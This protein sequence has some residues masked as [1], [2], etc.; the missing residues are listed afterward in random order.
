MKLKLIAD[1][2]DIGIIYPTTRN[3]VL[4]IISI[5]LLLSTAVA[6]ARTNLGVLFMVFFIESSKYQQP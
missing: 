4:V 5:A 6:V 1:P 3:N 2:A